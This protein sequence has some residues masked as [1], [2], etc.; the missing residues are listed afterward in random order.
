[1]KVEVAYATPQKQL[2]ITL[3]VPVGTTAY[4]AVVL[5]NIVDEFDGINPESDA[6]GIFSKVLDGKTMPSP[7]EY[8]LL[9]RDRV[10]V[11]RPLIIDPK[12]ARLNRASAKAAASENQKKAKIK[13]SVK[14]AVKPKPETKK[15]ITE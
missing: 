9:A 3:D 2:I 4:E 11:Y 14:L 15:K 7:R 8:Q 13:P 6:M 10:E 5:S 12:Q 1:M